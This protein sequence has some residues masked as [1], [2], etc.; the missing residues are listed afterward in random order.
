M[1]HIVQFI[2]NFNEIWRNAAILSTSTEPKC[3]DSPRV[4][5]LLLLA[6]IQQILLIKFVVVRVVFGYTWHIIVAQCINS[7]HTSPFVLHK[8]PI[9]GRRP[10]KWSFVCVKI[11][12]SCISTY[13][14]SNHTYLLYYLDF[15]KVNAILCEKSW[16]DWKA[17]HHTN[18]Q[19]H[20]LHYL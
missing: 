14:S 3:W 13:F 5:S 11:R 10:V 2:W 12:Q 18:S 1:R 6:F 9:R 19:L 4:L 7:T 17:P 15:I 20:F 8:S 16:V